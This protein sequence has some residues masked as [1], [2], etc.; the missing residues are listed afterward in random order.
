MAGLGSSLTLHLLAIAVTLAMAARAVPG[1][2]GTLGP[3]KAMPTMT[4]VHP[5]ALPR[6][7]TQEDAGIEVPERHGGIDLPGFQFDYRKVAGRANWLFPFVTGS[8][9]L[10]M[11]VNEPAVSLG[12]GFFERLAGG[13]EL[14]LSK[15]A[16]RISDDELQMIVDAAWSRRDRWRVFSSL[17]ALTDQYDGN[18]GQLPAVFRT[19]EQQN[20]LQ[21]YVDA[22]F[23][24]AR[25]W[26]ELGLAADHQDFIDFISKYSTEHPGTKT[27]SELLFL[28]DKIAQASYD[29]LVTLID[30]IP[31][32]DLQL[33]RKQNPSAYD[34]LVRIQQTYR[35][36]LGRRGLIARDALRRYY[37]AARLSILT[38]IVDSTPDGYRANDARYLIGEIFWKQDRLGD[39]R[40]W[41]QSLTIDPTDSYVVEYAR[42]VDAMRSGGPLDV[43]QINQILNSERGRWLTFSATRLRHFGYHFDTY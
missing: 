4:I 43:L 40:R 8:P 27:R 38:R 9:S 21:P 28:L 13:D 10:E 6:S 42:I 20:G 22:P 33:T 35:M 7:G 18:R 32:E 11:I 14:V 25:L 17:R 37:D 3:K 1:I 16:L 15:P 29:A 31:E 19:Y 26:A 23:R 41:W 24:D 39:A 5:D 30:A 12:G 36:E 34:G 2:R